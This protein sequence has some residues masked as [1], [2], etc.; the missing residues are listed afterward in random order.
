MFLHGRGIEE[1]GEKNQKDKKWCYENK[2]DLSIETLNNRENIINVGV[3]WE[4]DEY[5]EN[6]EVWTQVHW[7]WRIG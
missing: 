1:D 2:L 3:A 6:Q 7:Q 4:G 5:E